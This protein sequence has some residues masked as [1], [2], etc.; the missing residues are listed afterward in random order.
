MIDAEYGENSISRRGRK[1]R[2][3]SKVS[4]SW[5]SWRAWRL[6]E[7][8]IIRSI[9]VYLGSSAVPFALFSLWPFFF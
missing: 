5:F 4:F 2:K 8:K 1:D 3:S 7:S 6:G 9:S